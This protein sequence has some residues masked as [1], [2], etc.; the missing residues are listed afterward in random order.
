MFESAAWYVF[1]RADAEPPVSGAELG[2]LATVSK[3]GAS[4]STAET[5][6]PFEGILGD[7]KVIGGGRFFPFGGGTA[8]G[9]GLFATGSVSGGAGS[10][11]AGGGG[12]GGAGFAVIPS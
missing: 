9:G 12:G 10:G 1:R 8:T 7:L 4:C 2:P 5:A 11:P 3:L 6:P